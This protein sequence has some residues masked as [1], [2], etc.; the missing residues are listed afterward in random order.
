M[1]AIK[2]FLAAILLFAGISSALVS[3]DNRLP[4][5]KAVTVLNNDKEPIIEIYGRH[6]GSD[7]KAV[8]VMVND[9]GIFA[10]VLKV[11]PKKVRIQLTADQLCNG[12]ITLR[13]LVNRVVSNPSSISFYS[14]QPTLDSIQP[15]EAKP[16]SVIVV[17]GRNLSCQTIYNMVTF[18]DVP[19]QILGGNEDYLSVRVPEITAGN[20]LVR[21]N[22]NGYTSEPIPFTITPTSPPAKE[23]PKPDN[24]IVFNSNGAIPG[25]AGFSP[26]FSVSGNAIGSGVQADIWDTNFFGTHQ[27]IVNA[28]WRTIDGRQQVALLTL[29]MGHSN[30]L[31]RDKVGDFEKFVYLRI[32]YPLYPEKAYDAVTNPFWWGSSALCTEHFPFGE[33]YFN[34]LARAGGG[35]DSFVMSKA[36]AGPAKL[37]LALKIVAPDLFNYEEY[38]HNYEKAG[39]GRVIM[40]KVATVL[41]DLQKIQ[42]RVPVPLFNVGNVTIIDES[43]TNGRITS[44]NVAFYSS[45]IVVTNQPQL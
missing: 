43:G 34:S 22:V 35:V 24:E 45:V 19:T 38:G 39:N 2:I 4:E 26:M 36:I 12:T 29:N 9:N 33:I 11:R 31:A 3:A 18:N 25:S 30:S 1:K 27:A 44:N 15:Q 17:R 8:M 21:L 32:N 28:P 16:G 20:A 13:V 37:S 5:I 23:E 42:T 10:K 40:P 6:F 41:I 7:L 14:G